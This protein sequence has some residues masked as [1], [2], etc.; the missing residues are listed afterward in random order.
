MC[1]ELK[2]MSSFFFFKNRWLERNS[3]K[4]PEFRCAP[5]FLIYSAVL[6]P[7]LLFFYFFP[8]M[9]LSPHTS[10]FPFLHPLS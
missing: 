2:N 6:L 3:E 7:P 5:S 10:S 9:S 4:G 1:S 8:S